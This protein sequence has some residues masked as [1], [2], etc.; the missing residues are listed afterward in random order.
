MIPR[1]FPKN[2]FHLRLRGIHLARHVLARVYTPPV[3]MEVSLDDY[4]LSDQMELPYLNECNCGH[5]VPSHGADISILGKPEY[6][7]RGRVAVRIDE[8]LQVRCCAL[9]VLRMPYNFLIEPDGKS[10]CGLCLGWSESTR[11]TAISC[12]VLYRM[13]AD[14]STLIFWMRTSSRYAS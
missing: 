4:L 14:S 11:L 6:Q 12:H 5:D 8:L 1:V 9:K 3:G 2:N 13:L 7:R 10:R